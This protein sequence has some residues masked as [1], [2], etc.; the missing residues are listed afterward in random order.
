MPTSAE[1]LVGIP[2]EAASI[3]PEHGNPEKGELEGLR[4]GN[5]HVVEEAGHISYQ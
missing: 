3:D 5:I 4:D 1:L 2:I